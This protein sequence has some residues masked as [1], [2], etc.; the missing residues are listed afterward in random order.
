MGTSL[1]VFIPLLACLL[2]AL[3]GTDDAEPPPPLPEGDSGLAARYPGDVG[4]EGDP[5]V[6][7]A[8]GFEEVEAPVLETGLSP[9]KGKRWDGVW[10]LVR[11]TRDPENV[12]SSRQ[13]VEITHTEPRSWSAPLERYR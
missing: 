8:D 6:V 12:H 9:Q 1:A 4:I 5:A 3:S 2:L 7:F 10:G 11:I 13:A